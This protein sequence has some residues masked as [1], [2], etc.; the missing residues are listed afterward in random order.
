MTPG[1][2]EIKIAAADGDIHLC[3]VSYISGPSV[4][5]TVRSPMFG[6]GTFTAPDLFDA[7]VAFRLYLE[8]R[9]YLLLCNAARRDAYP[10]RMAR[11]MGGGRKVYLLCMGCQARMSDLVDSLEEA[12]LEL[13]T[14]VAAQKAAYEAW[15]DSL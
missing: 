3:R 14:T 13:V 6:E 8:A 12:S 2:V 1:E 4:A 10:S 9:G 11:E 5:L 7:L 15:L